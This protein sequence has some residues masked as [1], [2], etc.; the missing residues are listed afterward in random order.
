MDGPITPPTATITESTASPTACTP[1]SEKSTSLWTASGP[2]TSNQSCSATP[3]K[4]VF[5]MRIESSIRNYWYFSRNL[6]VMA[7]RT[8][9]RKWNSFENCTVLPQGK[10]TACW[11]GTPNCKENYCKDF[12]HPRC[13]SFR[14]RRSRWC[15]CTSRLCNARSISSKVSETRQKSI[16]CAT[17]SSWRRNWSKGRGCMSSTTKR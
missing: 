10:S 6:F 7:S 8:T 3:R 5:S 9:Y 11:W 2:A 1:I 13:C 4:T 17:R 12:Y 16:G 14:R 15:Q